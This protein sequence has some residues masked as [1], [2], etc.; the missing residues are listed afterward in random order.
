MPADKGHG[1]AHE[2][3][4]KLVCSLSAGEGN[5]SMFVLSTVRG[6]DRTVQCGFAPFIYTHRS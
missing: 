3:M 2:P 5:N 1:Q 6:L 4:Y